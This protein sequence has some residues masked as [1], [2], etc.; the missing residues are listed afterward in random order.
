MAEGWQG[1]DDDDDDDDNDH[2]D[3]DDCIIAASGH[4]SWKV[5]IVRFR[6]RL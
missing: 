1:T 4:V 3:D 5:Q 6:R 2:D